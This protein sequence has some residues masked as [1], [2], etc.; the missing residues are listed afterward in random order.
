MALHLFLPLILLGAAIIQPV[1]ALEIHPDCPR[2]LLDRDS[3]QDLDPSEL[4]GQLFVRVQMSGLFADS[5]YFVDMGPRLPSAEIMSHYL[6]ATP[7]TPQELQRFVESHFAPP[8]TP[9]L[10]T[11]SATSDLTAAH[12]RRFFRSWL[13]SGKIGMVA[14][15]RRNSYPRSKPNMPFG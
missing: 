13:R 4:Y 3:V 2:I 14:P 1:F 8:P 12:N 10:P 9:Q 7:H 11:F 5:K 6:S 15:L